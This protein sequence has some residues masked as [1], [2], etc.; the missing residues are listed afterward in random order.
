MNS[1]WRSEVLAEFSAARLATGDDAPFD[2]S[3]RCSCRGG[4]MQ[5]E[6]PVLDAAED[7]AD[8]MAGGCIIEEPA[9]NEGDE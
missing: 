4:A 1:L 2:A 3:E 6:E 9:D 8:G 5:G 7:A